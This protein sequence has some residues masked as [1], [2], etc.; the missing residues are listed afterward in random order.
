MKSQLAVV[1]TREENV[2]PVLSTVNQVSR[3]ISR[4]QAGLVF[5]GVLGLFHFAW[6]LLVAV[7]WA[8]PLMNFVFWMHFLTPPW[9]VEPFHAGTAVILVFMTSAIGFAVGYLAALLW[10]WLQE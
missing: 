5:A 1:D 6:A 9:H 10:N 3:R 2:A 7:G 8:Q 4:I